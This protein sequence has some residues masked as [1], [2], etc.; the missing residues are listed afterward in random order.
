MA[1]FSIGTFQPWNE[2]DFRKKSRNL[3]L[4][5]RGDYSPIAEE[6]RIAYPKS[7][8][9]VRAVPLTT[10]YLATMS[11][12]YTR[13][14]V[15]RF[16]GQLP[17]EA[18]RKLTDT[19][20]RSG[21]DAVM[22]KAEQ[23]LWTQNTV[24]LVVLP[25]GLR[26]VRVM[27]VLPWQ[28][29]VTVSDPLRADSP[30]GWSKL[31]IQVPSAV[32]AGQVIYGT[33]TLTAT[34]AWT[35]QGGRKVGIYRPD[36]THGLGRIPVVILHR[37]APD[38]GRWA[39]PVNEAVLNLAVTLCLQDADNENII[40]H[41]AWPQRV[42][43][44][45]DIGQL[46]EEVQFGP[47]RLISLVKS[48][49]A[50]STSPTLRVVQG[51]VPVSELASFAE[52]RIRLYCSLLGLDPTD[53]L[54]VNTST[55][56]AARRIQAQERAVLRSRILPVL[57]KGENDLARLVAEILNQSEPL[58]IPVQDLQVSVTYTE[59]VMSFDPVQE[60]TALEKRIQMGLS[61]PADLLAAEEGISRTEAQ[62]RIERNLAEVRALA[63][64]P[65]KAP[66]PEVEKPEPVVTE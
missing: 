46:V 30:E 1:L 34:E 23:A 59:P 22:D 65:S 66:V 45:A 8:L 41:C 18:W 62:R 35:E 56:A 29:E 26:K 20:T 10:H 53:F 64:A 7:D 13:P 14:V 21:I 25:D 31:E 32:A 39:G 4:L 63:P 52:H 28:A 5:S 12:R 16:L 37:V 24:I 54:R 33:M 61:S 3:D 17:E 51:Q 49:T 40:R 19:Y 42:I 48:D 43:E 36:G 50:S 57:A 60:V 2:V 11:G 44:G 55:T 9:P 27:P 47:D 58:Q 38:P 15:R 6:L